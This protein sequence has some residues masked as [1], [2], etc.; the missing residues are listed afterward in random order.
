[1]IFQKLVGILTPN[2]TG[3]FL[4]RYGPV[5]TEIFMSSSRAFCSA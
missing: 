5:K 4:R 1:M 3:S 2:L